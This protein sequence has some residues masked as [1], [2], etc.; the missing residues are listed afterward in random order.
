[1]T[2]SETIPG[3]VE[4]MTLPKKAPMNRTTMR[5]T[6][7]LARAQGMIKIMKINKQA[8]DTGLRPYTSLKGAMN[9]DPTARPIRYKVNPK[10][11]TVLDVPNSAAISATP[12]V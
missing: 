10:V 4:I 12:E 11:T 3:A 6:T 7:D 9:I 8:T 1:L 2:K 5:V